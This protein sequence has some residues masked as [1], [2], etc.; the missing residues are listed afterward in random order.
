MSEKKDGVLKELVGRLE[1][2][3]LLPEELKKKLREGGW[4]IMA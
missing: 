4:C 1:R 2:S 3:E